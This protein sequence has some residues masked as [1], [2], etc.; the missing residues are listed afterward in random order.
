MKSNEQAV[1]A[2]IKV[3]FQCDK[4]RIQFMALLI[5]AL[6]KLAD[7]SLAQWCLAIN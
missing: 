6:L 5:I 7:S 3:H 2:A 4:R 1:Y